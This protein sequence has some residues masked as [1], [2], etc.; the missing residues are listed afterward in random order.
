MLTCMDIADTSAT[1]RRCRIV[2]S[3][4]TTDRV[5]LFLV[6]AAQPLRPRYINNIPFGR[7]RIIIIVIIVARAGAT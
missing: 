5:Q 7:A 1:G 3:A 6:R 2:N 4:L